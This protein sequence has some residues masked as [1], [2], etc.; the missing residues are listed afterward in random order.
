MSKL[1]VSNKSL[2]IDD[3]NLSRAWCRLLLHVL[4]HPGTQVAP[5][6]L[7]LTGFRKNNVVP[8]DPALRK[9]LDQL[10]ERKKKFLVE[11]IAFAIFPQRIWDSSRGD[12][13]QFFDTYRRISPR[14]RS[15][16]KRA[17]GRGMYFERL[18][19]YGRGPCEGNQLEW[20]LSQYNS[21]KN[22]RC[23][24]LQATTFD[25]ARD[26]VANAQLG[27]PCLQQ[28]SFVPTEAGLV[29]NAF[30]ATQ[31][32]FDKAY[33]NYLGLS[34]LGAFMAR[35]MD[36]PMAQL[37]VMVGVAKLERIA[38]RDRDLARLIDA[39]TTLVSDRP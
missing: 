7:R 3:N 21:R 35:E 6:V 15:M 29:L 34:Q 20:I 31:Q 16:N 23:S 14:L 37:N 39:A 19:M 32:I 13:F 17:N 18:I 38:K 2:L 27:F 30:Y 10:L 33:G 12:R 5:L 26:H 28:I 8:E 9:A 11:D 25:P 36:M 24:M 4:E 1:S 22:V